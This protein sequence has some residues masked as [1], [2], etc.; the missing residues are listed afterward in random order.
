[1]HGWCG[2]D[3]LARPHLGGIKDSQHQQE[4]QQEQQQSPIV[5]TPSTL[6]RVASRANQHK[7]RKYLYAAAAA[8]FTATVDFWSGD[9]M[10]TGQMVAVYDLVVVRTC[11]YL[12]L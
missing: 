9:F 4:E 12:T 8:V 3:S 10:H 7:K 11:I 5:R 2:S 1:M 6:Y